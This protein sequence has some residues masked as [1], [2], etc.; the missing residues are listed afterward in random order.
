M[1]RYI[2]RSIRMR[3]A[4]ALV[5]PDRG[6]WIAIF[7]VLVMD[8]LEQNVRPQEEAGDTIQHQGLQFLLE[9]RSRVV[10]LFFRNFLNLQSVWDT[11]STRQT[12]TQIFKKFGKS[13]SYA[14]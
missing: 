7:V 11:T 2:E 9:S 14:L 6:S 1:R 10:D 12:S 13:K 3:S 5:Q 4:P 8:A